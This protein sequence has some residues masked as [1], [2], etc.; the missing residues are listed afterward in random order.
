[1]AAICDH[2][3]PYAISSNTQR[4]RRS[5]DDDLILAQIR[6]DRFQVKEVMRFDRSGRVVEIIN[7]SREM[8]DQRKV[9][10][11]LDAHS[12]YS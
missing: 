4:R 11:R 8:A 6:V 12:P 10:I 3:L 5:I 1:M 2:G 7:L 9:C